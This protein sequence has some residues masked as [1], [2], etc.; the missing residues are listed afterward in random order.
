LADRG[1]ASVANTPMPWISDLSILYLGISPIF[2]RGLDYE[3][4]VSVGVGVL[5]GQL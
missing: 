4:C 3:V 1:I 5:T 2:D